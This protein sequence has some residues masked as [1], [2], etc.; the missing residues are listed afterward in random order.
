MLTKLNVRIRLYKKVR[1][2]N[3]LFQPRTYFTLECS[4]EKYIKRK[5]KIT[6]L[7]RHTAA[8]N[9]RPY[10]LIILKTDAMCERKTG[11]KCARIID[12]ESAN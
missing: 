6:G 9:S 2:K 12:T 1:N 10:G 8:I 3:S 11:E 7:I 5:I 4:L